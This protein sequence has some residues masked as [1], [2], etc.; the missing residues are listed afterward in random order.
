[1]EGLCCTKTI[2]VNRK[3]K[4]THLLLLLLG[5][6]ILR[7]VVGISWLSNKDINS[8]NTKQKWVDAVEIEFCDIDGP[9]ELELLLE[10]PLE[11]LVDPRPLGVVDS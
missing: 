3:F 6:T 1:M 4:K 11:L 7:N 9:L 2:R 10:F 5:L 8:I